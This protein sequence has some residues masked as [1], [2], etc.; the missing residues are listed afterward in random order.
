MAQKQKCNSCAHCGS[1]VSEFATLAQVA[2][3]TCGSRTAVYDW[4]KK[5]KIELV[6][7][8][9]RTL[10]RWSELE[11]FANTA[12]PWTPRSTNKTNPAKP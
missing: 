11:R 3:F 2:A 6:R 12:E 7:L 4:A 9:G 10:V 1:R 8:G 5:G